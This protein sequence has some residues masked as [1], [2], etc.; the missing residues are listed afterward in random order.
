MRIKRIFSPEWRTDK[1]LYKRYQPVEAAVVFRHQGPVYEALKGDELDENW[2]AENVRAWKVIKPV[3][4]G[5]CDVSRE[6]LTSWSGPV[7][8]NPQQLMFFETT[9]IQAG[10][11]NG[12]QFSSLLF[13]QLEISDF[14]PIIRKIERRLERLLGKAETRLC[15]LSIQYCGRQ[16]K[17]FRHRAVSRETGK[18]QATLELPTRLLHVDD[19]AVRLVETGAWEER[20]HYAALSYC[21]GAKPLTKLTEATL[22]SFRRC[23][24]FH[25]LPKTIQDAI[26]AT[27]KL[28]LSYIWVGALCIIQGNVAEWASEAGRIASVYGG[29]HVTLAASSAREVYDGLTRPA[30]NH[31]AALRTAVPDKSGRRSMQCIVGSQEYRAAALRN[32]LTSRGWTLQE[33]LLSRRI[34]YFSSRGIV[35]QCNAGALSEYMPWHMLSPS[36]STDQIQGLSED[37]S[38][39]P[40]LVRGF[41]KAD[42]TYGSDRLPAFAGLERGQDGLNKGAY[43]TGGAYLASLW[44]LHIERQ[45]F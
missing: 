41:T 24:P 15:S 33:R 25:S 9:E 2:I 18:P 45:L 3:T 19:D 28:G 22:E 10:S 13:S 4:D 36:S 8:T 37:R 29:S 40:A 31:R 12:C 34:L 43:Q 1:A 42:L 39:W 11:E 26:H 44:R 5:C 32:V 20:S 35:W 16:G 14:L 17:A 21:W 7:E 38:L 23:I 30:E 6:K 27:R